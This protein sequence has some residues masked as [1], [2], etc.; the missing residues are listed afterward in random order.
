MAELDTRPRSRMVSDFGSAGLIFVGLAVIT[1]IACWQNPE[2]SSGWPEPIAFGALAVFFLGFWAGARTEQRSAAAAADQLQASA[3][4]KA[5]L[6]AEAARSAQEAE[7][8]R[9]R[10]E[11]ELRS[12]RLA[13]EELRREQLARGPSRLG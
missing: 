8:V 4:E 9:E 3:E 6:R 1:A 5:R 12:V 13:Y 2:R 11:F 10:L 7:Q